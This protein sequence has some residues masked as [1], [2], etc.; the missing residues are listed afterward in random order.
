MQ[1]SPDAEFG[2]A[3]RARTAALRRVDGVGPA[4]L[5]YLQKAYRAP[6]GLG[7]LK[8]LGGAIQLTSD[9]PAVGFFHHVVGLDVSSPAPAASYIAELARSHD[10]GGGLR[11]MAAGS[12]RVVGG[13]YCCWDAFG[14]QDLRVSVSIPGGVKA[15]LLRPDG[16]TA[17]APDAP[18]GWAQLAVSALL[19]SLCAP[20]PGFDVR[21]LPPPLSPAD[22]GGFLHAATQ[23]MLDG[24]GGG[25]AV[26]SGFVDELL[27]RYFSQSLRHEQ[28]LRFFEGLQPSAP[29]CAAHVAA[30]Q[31]GLGLLPEAIGTLSVALQA[32][33]ATGG[34]GGGGGGASRVALL[35]E[36][37]ELLLECQMGEHA[38]PLARQLAALAPT[39]LKP[40][41]LLARAFALAANHVHA[42]RALNSA[43]LPHVREPPAAALDERA[44]ARPL[45]A[46][47][48]AEA[49]AAAASDAAAAAEAAAGGGGADG[50]AEGGGGA[51]SAQRGGCSLRRA[52][53]C[54]RRR[55]EWR[56][57]SASAAVAAAVAATRRGCCDCL[58]SAWARRR[59]RCTKSWSS[60]PTIS[61]GSDSSPRAPLRSRW[62][63]PMAA[64]ARA[65]GGGCA[66]V[67]STGWWAPSTQISRRLWA[68]R[69]RRQRFTPSGSSASP[70]EA[71]RSSAAATPAPA[72]AAA[73]ARRRRRRRSVGCRRRSGAAARSWRRG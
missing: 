71:P 8:L 11:E 28:A 3:L 5:C 46:A 21:A 29:W 33:A 32:A 52:P 53:R 36:Q 24:G 27:A 39:R 22:E 23:L 35:C 31:R 73:A 51:S 38:L 7:G 54:R 25:G 37:V 69:T 20:P 10:A 68:G 30:A 55:C 61:A 2:A 43:P 34:G 16:T 42:L 19:R 59:L 44:M 64:A 26:R 65:A 4:D 18:E 72:A 40:W 12:W 17:A 47:R 41:I 13:V 48:D 57:C 9:Q 70:Q 60:S 1:D 50:G 14:R 66:N 67:G 63:V 45:D 49:A 58:R 56:R 6:L 15:S 62:K